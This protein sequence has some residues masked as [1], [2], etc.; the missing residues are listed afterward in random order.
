MRE[1]H[2]G[3]LGQGQAQFLLKVLV[4]YVN[5]PVTESPKEKQRTDENKRDDQ[6][7]AV[8][9][10]EHTLLVCAHRV[11]KTIPTIQMVAVRRNFVPPRHTWGIDS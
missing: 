2:P 4:H 5:H 8:I 3:G 1:L 11:L 7:L 9:R 10:D 6:I